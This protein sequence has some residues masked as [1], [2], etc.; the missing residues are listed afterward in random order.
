[1]LNES[2]FVENL[3]CSLLPVRRGDWKDPCILVDKYD[4]IDA[5]RTNQA[6]LP[7]LSNGP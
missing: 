1:M 3:L 2:T 5:R 6:T 7:L 4:G